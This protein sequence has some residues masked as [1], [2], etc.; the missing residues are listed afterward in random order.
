MIDVLKNA[1]EALIF[2]NTGRGYVQTCKCDTIKWQFLFLLMLFEGQPVWCNLLHVPKK[3]CGIQFIRKPV[4]PYT[5][6]LRNIFTFFE[7]LE[8]RKYR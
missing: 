7:D 6:V 8:I 5:H 1:S 3:G 2:I 4:V